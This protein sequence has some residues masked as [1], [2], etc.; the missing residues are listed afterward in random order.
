[1]FKCLSKLF[2][3]KSSASATPVDSPS[4]TCSPIKTRLSIE[5]GEIDSL[6]D[7]LVK[8][9][10]S[11]DYESV[12]KAADVKVTSQEVLEAAE[13]AKNLMAIQKAAKRPREFI[14]KFLE[15]ITNAGKK[16]YY[17]ARVFIDCCT[18]VVDKKFYQN[19]CFKPE[20]YYRS[21][22]E[23]VNIYI[24]IKELQGRGYKI[25]VEAYAHNFFITTDD[26]V[27]DALRI[28]PDDLFNLKTAE[29][30][31]HLLACYTVNAKA[32]Y[33]EFPELFSP[34]LVKE[35]KLGEK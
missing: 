3:S 19:S 28:H 17:G 14:E 27:A 26:N 2:G 18:G 22:L 5:A 13:H 4:P 33:A 23:T 10:T 7:Y 32:L 6:I 29:E 15:K 30:I 11:L 20:D 1:M 25:R 35:F 24:A 8:I 34:E 12:I 21:L 16:G 31:D 9:R